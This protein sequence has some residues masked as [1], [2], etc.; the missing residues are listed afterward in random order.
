MTGDVREHSEM[1]E[2]R[3]VTSLHQTLLHEYQLDLVSRCGD[4]GGLCVGTG[5]A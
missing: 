5:A 3:P 1:P 2:V 4:I